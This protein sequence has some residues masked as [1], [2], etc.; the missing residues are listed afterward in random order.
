MS[1]PNLK[2]RRV[3]I[4]MMQRQAFASLLLAGAVV[5]V[6]GLGAL[7][8]SVSLTVT[9][10][11]DAVRFSAQGSVKELRV[12]ILALS[13]QKVFDSGPVLGNALDWKLLNSQGQPV[14][15]GVYLYTVTVK[16]PFGNVTKKLGKLAVLRGKGIAAPPLSGITVGQLA[17]PRLQPQQQ[18]I[19]EN[20]IVTGRL[21]VGASALGPYRLDV[22]DDTAAELNQTVLR[23]SRQ[24]PAIGYVQTFFQV[25]NYGNNAVA[26]SHMRLVFARGDR[27]NPLPVLP[28]DRLG[29]LIYSGWD[30]S[31]FQNPAA[32]FAYVAGPVGPGNVPA[33]LTFETGACFSGCANPRR[34]RM[35]I[36]PDGN[37][38]INTTTPG[39]VTNTRFDVVGRV[40]FR[41][42]EG[43]TNR[44]L[45]FDD[46]S[47]ALRIYTDAVTGTPGDLILG[48][49]PNGHLN[50]L[51]LKQSTGNVGIGTPNP[52]PQARLHVAG[53]VRISSFLQLD[54]GTLPAVAP[55]NAARLAVDPNGIL[56]FNQNEFGNDYFAI[57]AEVRSCPQPNQAINSVKRNGSVSCVNVGPGGEPLWTRDQG[58]VRLVDETNR[59]R[60]GP[61]APNPDPNTKL[62]IRGL[63]FTRDTKTLDVF[64]NQPL[65]FFTLFDSEQLSM[66]R[67]EVENEP[68]DPIDGPSGYPEIWSTLTGAWWPYTIADIVYDNLAGFYAKKAFRAWDRGWRVLGPRGS[69]G[70]ALK[71]EADHTHGGLFASWFN[72]LTAVNGKGLNQFLAWVGGQR[73]ASHPIAERALSGYEVSPGGFSFIPYPPVYFTNPGGNAANPHQ[74]TALEECLSRSS[75]PAGAGY[76]RPTHVSA[77]EVWDWE[78]RGIGGIDMNGPDVDPNN[79]DLVAWL[80]CKGFLW[81]RE[82]EVAG[83]LTVRGPKSF[84]QDHP[85]DPTKQ[86]VYVALEGPEAGT[87]IRGTAQL[88]NG[89]A[90]IVLPEHFSLVTND[91][92]LTVQLTPLGDWLQLYVVE[93]SAKR[94]IVREAQGKSGKFDYLVQGVRK[95]YENHQVIQDKAK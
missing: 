73:P 27:D 31:T 86:I 26:G 52:D 81:V 72:A 78:D 29:S 71:V 12:E 7:A 64:D 5:F 4:M 11:S 21:T 33:S 82:L 90:V 10:Y 46:I 22:R 49:Y 68:I 47:G 42:I 30:G 9:A 66:R 84:A 83:S 60:I 85:T 67:Y 51:V 43:N 77:I 34:P 44:V 70:L 39:A 56:M 57:Q 93:K 45:I 18:Q 16:D 61:P 80:S 40:S 54:G 94:I 35:V 28:E 41:P 1:R 69:P 55:Q 88:I 32:V 25:E 91:E 38:G 3:R 36:T 89:E 19:F 53:N 6:L 14:A 92:G 59:V 65:P 48:T 79:A 95:G 37:V 74:I 76:P 87:Y 17:E 2:K 8:Q 23:V 58:I 50:Q 24:Q 13:G 62:L 20:V 15:N 63:G 75:E